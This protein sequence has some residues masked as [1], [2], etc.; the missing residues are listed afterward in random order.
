MRDVDQRV[1]EAMAIE[2]FAAGASHE[3]VGLLRGKL[4]ASFPHGVFPRR[5]VPLIAPC[6]KIDLGSLRQKHQPGYL[7][8][9]A[10]LVEGGGRAI[11]LL[12]RLRSRIETAMPLP[13]IL[14][15]GIAGADRDRAGVDIAVVDVPTLLGA[16]V[17]RRRVSSG[18]PHQSAAQ[19]GEQQHRGTA[20]R[21]APDLKVRCPR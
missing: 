7:K 13:R 5:P 10:G 9:G 8:I 2:D 6:L 11:L 3:R 16:S 21:G 17:E 4:L 12:A 19:T 15:M 14:I 1:L 20:E 18:M